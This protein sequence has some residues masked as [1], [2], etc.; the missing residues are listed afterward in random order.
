MTHPSWP[1]NTW[2]IYTSDY[3]TPAAYYGVTRACEPVHV[4][5]DLPDFRPAVV[6]ISQ[7]PRKSL[8]LLTRVLSLQGRMLF[9]KTDRIDAPANDVMTLGPLELQHALAEER[10][11]FVEL[12]LT[13][14]TGARISNNLYWESAAESDLG[15]LNEMP[16]QSLQLSATA[17]ASVGASAVTIKLTNAGPTPALLAK[18]TLLD[19]AG[20]RV[21]PVYYEDNYL[22]LLPGESRDIQATCP[23][24]G[25]KCVAVA[26]R[27]W[28][29]APASVEIGRP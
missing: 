1:S 4:Q 2:Q 18:L 9:E 24:A 14:S 15:R 29:I 25:E 28:N 20:K 17:P 3:D 10:V 12:T 21:L 19:S 23:D 13:D 7:E 27:G 22:S 8:R 16:T 6:N 5:L 11:V 26:L